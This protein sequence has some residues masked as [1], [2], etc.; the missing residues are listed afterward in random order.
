MRKRKI[1]IS[2]SPKALNKID[3]DRMNFGG[4]SRSAYINMKIL[5]R[6]K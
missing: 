1:S 5:R 3:I 2:I 4:L 6:R